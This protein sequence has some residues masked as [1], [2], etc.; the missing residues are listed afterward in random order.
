MGAST[1]VFGLSGCYVAYIILNFSHLSSRPDK[2]CQIIVFLLLSLVLTA[3]LG[4]KNIDVMGHLGG[5]LTGI[6][7]GH[8]VMPCVEEQSFKKE[9]ASR[10]AYW[11]KIGTIVWFA[12]LIG[13]FYLFRAPEDKFAGANTVTIKSDDQSTNDTTTAAE[14]GDSNDENNFGQIGTESEDLDD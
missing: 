10:L 7:L 11:F 4:S 3:M 2:M 8:W 6:I 1:A 9:R 13:C 14:I 5:F 12:L